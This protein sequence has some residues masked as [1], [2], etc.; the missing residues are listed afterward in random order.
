MYPSDK[1]PTRWKNMRGCSGC[2]ASR[3]VSVV[4]AHLMR[5]S[6]GTLALADALDAV[7]AQR[8]CAQPNAGFLAQLEEVD[9]M[10]GH[11]AQD[12]EAPSDV[13]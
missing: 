5:A 1:Y 11:A 6:G 3:S 13:R 4:C 8:P 12:E 10:E 2:C 9:V 7:R